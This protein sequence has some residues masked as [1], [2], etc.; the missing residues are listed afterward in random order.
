MVAKPTLSVASTAKTTAP[1][2]KTDVVSSNNNN[3]DEDDP[4]TKNATSFV[5]I[6]GVSAK[7]GVEGDTQLP[8]FAQPKAAQKEAKKKA[9]PSESEDEWL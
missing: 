8:L 9:L 3:N 5:R 7:R 4:M 1:G 6:E 2:T